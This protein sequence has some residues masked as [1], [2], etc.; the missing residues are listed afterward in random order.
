MSASK[1]RQE[2]DSCD[3]SN[4]PKKRIRLDTEIRFRHNWCNGYTFLCNAWPYVPQQSFNACS[5]LQLRNESLSILKDH[6]PLFTCPDGNHFYSVLHFYKV[7]KFIVIDVCYARAL[8]ACSN[9]NQLKSLSSKSTWSR[10]RGQTLYGSQTQAK[11]KYDIFVKKFHEYSD[12]V[13]LLALYEKFTQN[14]ALGKCL[15]ETVGHKLSEQG[16]FPSDYWCHTGRNRLGQL[17][18]QVRDHLVSC[19]WQDEIKR[20]YNVLGDRIR[21]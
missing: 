18:V 12:Q 11:V 9:G 20:L 19:T 2:S 7:C 8:L 14:Q 10:Q 3:T 5:S 21:L 13:M 17:L 4:S 1:R 15:M 16:R 6:R